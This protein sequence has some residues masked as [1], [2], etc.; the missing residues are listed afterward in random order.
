MTMLTTEKLDIGYDR[1]CD[2]PPN[3]LNCM[4]AKE[5][6]K[7]QIGVWHEDFDD[8]EF[9]KAM[10]FYYEPRDFRDKEIHPAVFP[11]NLAKKV[12]ELFSHKGELVLDPFV[13]VGTTLV[14]AKDLKRNAVGFDIN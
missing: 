5:W 6:I 13:G 12:I 10:E 2:C 4:T 9:Q 1:I 8:K 3:N 7:S 11:I 14:A